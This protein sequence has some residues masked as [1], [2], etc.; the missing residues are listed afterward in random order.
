MEDNIYNIKISPKL[1]LAPIR[2]RPLGFVFVLFVS[3]INFGQLHTSLVFS[4]L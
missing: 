4:M 3:F 2:T 1:I